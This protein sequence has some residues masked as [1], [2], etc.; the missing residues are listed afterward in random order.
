MGYAQNDGVNCAET[1]RGTGQQ[2]MA[3]EGDMGL[4][5]IKGKAA[6]AGHEVG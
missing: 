6:T 5:I 3:R 1:L 2:K 4:W